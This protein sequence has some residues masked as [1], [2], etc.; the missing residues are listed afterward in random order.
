MLT[1]YTSNQGLNREIYESTAKKTVIN[2][3]FMH[4]RVIPTETKRLFIRKDIKFISH[5]LQVSRN[6][7]HLRAGDKFIHLLVLSSGKNYAC[8]VV[9]LRRHIPY[10]TQPIKTEVLHSIAHTFTYR[11][12]ENCRSH[13]YGQMTI[14]SSM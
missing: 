4:A 5:T 13:N 9:S 14:A 2:G 8:V 12:L 3:M 1:Y 11:Y 6:L 7:F 10:I